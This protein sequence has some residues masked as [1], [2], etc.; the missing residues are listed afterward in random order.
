MVLGKGLGSEHCVGSLLL[1]L[2]KVESLL[3]YVAVGGYREP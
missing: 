2:G 3:D 1:R